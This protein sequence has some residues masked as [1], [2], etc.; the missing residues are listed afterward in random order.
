[1]NLIGKYKIANYITD[2]PAH[3]VDVLTFLK[4]L[5]YRM[6]NMDKNNSHEGCGVING[7]D[8]IIT[9]KSNPALKTSNIIYIGRHA[10]SPLL[11]PVNI[12]I[13]K[14]STVFISVPIPPGPKEIEEEMKAIER[15]AHDLKPDLQDLL[16]SAASSISTHTEYLHSM[17]RI[18]AIFNSE[19]GMPQ[20]EELLTLVSEVTHYEEYFMEFP[21]MKL[22]ESIQL[23]LDLLQLTPANLTYLVCSEDQLISFLEGKSVLDDNILKR[24]FHVLSLHFPVNDQR[25]LSI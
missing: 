6:W 13:K 4:E 8:C 9:Y 1:M 11:E 25:F 18:N 15:K 19:P 17:Q 22:A 2:F 5:P 10:E 16:S 20:Y 3:R 14:Q 7:L 12:E 23:R 21:K 24:L